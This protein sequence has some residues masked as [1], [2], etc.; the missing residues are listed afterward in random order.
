[1]VEHTQAAQTLLMAHRNTKVVV[2][3]ELAEYHKTVFS[4]MSASQPLYPITEVAIVLPLRDP[5]AFTELLTALDCCSTL[6]HLSIVSEVYEEEQWLP[7]VKCLASKPPFHSVYLDS[8]ESPMD[9]AV[10]KQLFACARD[11]VRISGALW[12]SA[13]QSS[14]A[15]VCSNIPELTLEFGI[16]NAFAADYSDEF[17]PCCMEVK[18]QQLLVGRDRAIRSLTL[19]EAGSPELIIAL[20]MNTSLTKL[21]HRA[22][23]HEVPGLIRASGC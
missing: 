20:A 14:V 3:D 5:Q 9:F 7:L 11:S 18:W 13:T 1:M 10:M 19:D 15:S 21:F 22:G 17:E 23:G 6:C 16:S 8:P 4:R 12:S 2:T